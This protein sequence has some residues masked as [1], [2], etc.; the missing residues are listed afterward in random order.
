VLEKSGKLMGSLTYIILIEPSYSSARGSFRGNGKLPRLRMELWGCVGQHCHVEEFK[1]SRQPLPIVNRHT[2]YLD[3]SGR[4]R[5]IT[6]PPKEMARKKIVRT[7]CLTCK[8]S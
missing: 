7:G 5:S 4:L 3:V 8:V 2:N 6:M 1:A